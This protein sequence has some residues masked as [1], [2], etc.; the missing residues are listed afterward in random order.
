MVGPQFVMYLFISPFCAQD[1][2]WKEK[3]LDTLVLSYNNSTVRSG[4]TALIGNFHFLISNKSSRCRQSGRLLDGT[5]QLD[6]AS[7]LKVVLLPSVLSGNSTF[8]IRL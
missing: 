6:L 1:K 8:P 5:S 7:L 2:C 3:S 4:L